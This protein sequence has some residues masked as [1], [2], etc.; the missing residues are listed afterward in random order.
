MTFAEQGLAAMGKNSN[1]N[2]Q[3]ASSSPFKKSN[4]AQ[5]PITFSELDP[6]ASSPPDW[7]DDCEA[8]SSRSHPPSTQSRSP[9]S[10][11]KNILDRQ[12]FEESFDLILERISELDDKLDEHTDFT[13]SGFQSICSHIHEL[14]AERKKADVIAKKVGVSISRRLTNLIDM[15]IEEN[16]L[17]TQRDE[18]QTKVLGKMDRRLSSFIDAEIE[19]HS[20]IGRNVE[21]AADLQHDIRRKVNNIIDLVIEDLPEILERRGLLCCR[22]HFRHTVSDEGFVFE[23]DSHPTTRHSQSQRTNVENVDRVSR[24]NRITDAPT[25]PKDNLLPSRH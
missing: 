1:E 15:G 18:A 2:T 21:E 5:R 3:K 16:A 22:C 11:A 14:S 12:Y 13:D 10:P 19:E 4:R 9:A 24:L 23:R 20:K 7:E 25:G 8:S 6:T 17:F